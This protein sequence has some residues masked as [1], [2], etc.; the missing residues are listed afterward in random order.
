[1]RGA[2]VL[3][4]PAGP[5]RR[6]GRAIT[7]SDPWFPDRPSR[8][9][10]PRTAESGPFSPAVRPPRSTRL[11]LTATLPKRSRSGGGRLHAGPADG[12]DLGGH[13]WV[14][15]SDISPARPS[16]QGRGQSGHR[17]WPR[18]TVHRCPASLSPDWSLEYDTR[19]NGAAAAQTPTRREEHG[20]H[21][22]HHGHDHPVRRP[23]GMSSTMAESPK[24]ATILS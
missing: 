7:E 20:N 11:K 22:I 2:R 5:T 24:S 6:P 3:R 12:P 14:R 13:Y 8:A 10:R 15:I 23:R 4:Y 1:M 18:R 16:E 17:R 19:P 21:G 9:L